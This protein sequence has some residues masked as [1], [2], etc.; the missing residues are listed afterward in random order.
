MATAKGLRKPP[1]LS[2]KHDGRSAQLFNHHLPTTKDPTEQN[3]LAD[4]PAPSHGGD[5]TNVA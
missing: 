3:G 1:V 2:K 5:Y 4:D